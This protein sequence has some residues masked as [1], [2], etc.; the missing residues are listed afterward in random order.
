VLHRS[1]RS[2]FNQGTF[3]ARH[4]EEQDAPMPAIGC[5]Q[6]RASRTQRPDQELFARLSLRNFRVVIASCGASALRYLTCSM[7]AQL[8]QKASARIV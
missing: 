4:A 5:G 1:A 8:W 7:N 2:L 6:L 3:T